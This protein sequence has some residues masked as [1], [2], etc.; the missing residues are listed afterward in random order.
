MIA[1]LEGGEDGGC[2][3]L[4]A[5]DVGRDGRPRPEGMGRIPCRR[6]PAAVS[7]H[8]RHPADEG[9]S[10]PGGRGGRR[11]PSAPV[12]HD[13]GGLAHLALGRDGPGAP[14]LL[15]Y[16]I[17]ERICGRVR[18]VCGKRERDRIRHRCPCREER[19]RLGVGCGLQAP[20]GRGAGGHAARPCGL[21]SW[22]QGGCGPVP[23]EGVS[24]RRPGGGPVR[25]G[26]RHGRGGG[27][28]ID[29]CLHL[30]SVPCPE[31]P[32]REIAPAGI[33]GEHM[34]VRGGGIREGKR[35]TCRPCALV[36]HAVVPAREELDR[37]CGVSSDRLHE[38]ALVV[39]RRAVPAGEDVAGPR[40][41]RLR[42]GLS[43][44]ALSHVVGGGVVG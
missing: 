21:I 36:P 26:W 29:G 17:E 18:H 39:C 41:G 8:R 22:L 34:G 31:L 20:I 5:R 14:L 13:S 30:G 40:R 7:A 24:R 35:R 12:G 28:G 44:H 1:H 23:R 32:L 16:R 37:A 15:R 43:G 10:R 6:L 3:A 42:E 33:P 19:C 4:C 27:L 9:V 2:R 38:R 25:A 11:C